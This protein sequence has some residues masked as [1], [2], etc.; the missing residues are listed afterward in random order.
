MQSGRLNR[1]FQLSDLDLQFSSVFASSFA[2]QFA[3]N[4][5]F[6]GV[7]SIAGARLQFMTQCE[8]SLSSQTFCNRPRT[9]STATTRPGPLRHRPS[10]RCSC[11]SRIPHVTLSIVLY[12]LYQ[13]I[14]SLHTNKA[15]RNPLIGPTNEALRIVAYTH[16]LPLFLRFTTR[17]R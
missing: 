15:G 9:P 8:S 5:P 16:T 1:D 11:C 12:E 3:S 6:D 14:I 4:A 10:R 2:C 13:R 7:A 17:A